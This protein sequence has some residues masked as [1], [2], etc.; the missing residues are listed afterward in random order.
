MQNDALALGSGMSCSQGAP[1][2]FPA[3]IQRFQVEGTLLCRQGVLVKAWESRCVVSSSYKECV[4]GM[5]GGKFFHE[6]SE[7]FPGNRRVKVL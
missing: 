6:S 7:L 1:L 5:S 3:H 2:S 4:V